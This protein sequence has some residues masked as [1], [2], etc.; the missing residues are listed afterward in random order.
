V[1]VPF[2]ALVFMLQQPQSAP[3]KESA[4]L[5]K[6]V[7]KI[8]LWETGEEVHKSLGAPRMYYHPRAERYFTPSEHD[9]AASVYGLLDDVYTRQTDAGE[10]QI[11]I[12]Y[13]LD[14]SESHLHPQLR[15]V[16]VDFEFDK[17]VTVRKALAAIA[18]A[19]DLCAAGCVL[20]GISRSSTPTLIAEPKISS[21]ANDSLA[22]SLGA[23]NEGLPSR[24]KVGM[25]A[26]FREEGTAFEQMPVLKLRLGLTNLATEKSL[27]DSERARLGRSARNAGLKTSSYAELEP[28]RP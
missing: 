3:A 18:E 15:V 1:I 20:T 7:E 25:T 9:A 6:T 14:E 26:W 8:R 22:R 5:P 4:Q 11:V 2:L 12:G 28:W 17:R 16:A 13:N 10:V 27:V 24:S 19:A 21:A 23:D